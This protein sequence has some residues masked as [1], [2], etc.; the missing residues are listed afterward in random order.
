MNESVCIS[1]L[2]SILA[3]VKRFRPRRATVSCFRLLA[4]AVTVKNSVADSVPL[5][6]L[7]CT[8]GRHRIVCI[9][10]I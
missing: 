4:Y 10:K 1:L 9:S 2:E 3:V 6:I 7:L 5:V 8:I